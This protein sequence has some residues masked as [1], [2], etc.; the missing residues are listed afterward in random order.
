MSEGLDRER[1]LAELRLRVP[2]VAATDAFV[3][4]AGGALLVDVRE[5]N[6]RASGMPAGALGLSRGFLE[7]RIEQ[8]EPDRQRD[9]LLLCGSGQR[10]LLAAEALQRLG[11]RNVSSVAGGIGA[12]KVAG[13]PVIAGA[14]DADAAERYA[15]QVLLPQVG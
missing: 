15:R 12:W 14:L 3:R 8:A 2:E 13:L 11:Y 5:D 9:I 1:W 4:Q 7:L 10:S 6:E